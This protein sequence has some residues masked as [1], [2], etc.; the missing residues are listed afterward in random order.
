VDAISDDVPIPATEFWPRFEPG[1][2]VIDTLEKKDYKVP[3]EQM[4]SK[5]AKETTS[6]PVREIPP[7]DWLDHASTTAL[8]MG[9]LLIV[10]AAVQ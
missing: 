10:V 2:S 4:E 6:A 1:M 8:I 9:M 3:D 5:L 7:M